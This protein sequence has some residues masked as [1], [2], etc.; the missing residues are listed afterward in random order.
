M[1][2][3]KSISH[4]P[5][6]QDDGEVM[7]VGRENNVQIMKTTRHLDRVTVPWTVLGTA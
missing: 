4:G 5:M 7:M 3:S 6:S 2:T 1:D